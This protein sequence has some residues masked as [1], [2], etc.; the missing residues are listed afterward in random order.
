MNSLTSIAL[1]KIAQE[2]QNKEAVTILATILAISVADSMQ[3]DAEFAKVV[4]CE[5]ASKLR[6]WSSQQ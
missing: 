2:L 4:A 1:S 3:Q 5:I 6:E